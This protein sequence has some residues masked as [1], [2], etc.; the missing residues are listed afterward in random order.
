MKIKKRHQLERVD[1]V[2]L[3]DDH[4][5]KIR[6]SDKTVNVFFLLVT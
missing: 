5:S 1:A 3:L 6:V 4:Y 2:F